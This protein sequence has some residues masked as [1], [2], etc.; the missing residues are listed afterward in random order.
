MNKTDESH[1][2]TD[3]KMGLLV[4]AGYQRGFTTAIYRS[5]EI[6]SKVNIEEAIVEPMTKCSS[7]QVILPAM[8]P[9]QWVCTYKNAAEYGIVNRAVR[10]SD[11][12]IL[13]I[14]MD[15]G[16]RGRR[17]LMMYMRSMLPSKAVMNV[18]AC[19][20]VRLS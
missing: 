12:A 9:N 5:A 7:L 3:S 19:N 17:C 16:V 4:N 6:A 11:A 20:A 13:T 1:I 10:R 18:R 2:E 14:S 15:I 8:P